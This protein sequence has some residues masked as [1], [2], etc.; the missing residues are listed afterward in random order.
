MDV[1]V[2]DHTAVL[3]DG[4]LGVVLDGIAAQVRV[5]SHAYIHGRAVA[6]FGLVLLAGDVGNAVDVNPAHRRMH[7][8]TTAR[9]G[10]SAVQEHLDGGNYITLGAFRQ[11]FN[12]ICDGGNRGVCPARAAAI[13][14]EMC[15]SAQFVL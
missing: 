9:A 15:V 1:L 12:S 7:V 10:G 2:S 14:G 5:A 3:R 13:Q 4:D 11:D 8:T 6:I